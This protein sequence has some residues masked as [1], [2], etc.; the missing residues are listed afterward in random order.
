M[1]TAGRSP[2]Q[3]CL[4]RLNPRSGMIWR[5]HHVTCYSYSGP[6]SLAPHVLRLRPATD[7]AQ[8][9]LSFDLAMTPAPK[10]RADSLDL[11]G[12]SV[13]QAWFVGENDS[14][15]IETVSTVDMVRHDPFDYLWAGPRS[16]PL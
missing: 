13:T 2:W 14:L 16:L 7:A 11:E 4:A 15:K 5:V 8:R 12:N 9:L 3:A 6:V 10:G 1:A